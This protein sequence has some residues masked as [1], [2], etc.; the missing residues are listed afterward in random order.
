MLANLAIERR[1]IDPD[2][3]RVSLLRGDPLRDS[4]P[5]VPT[6]WPMRPLTSM[7]RSVY[8]KDPHLASPG[9]AGEGPENRQP[10]EATGDARFRLTGVVLHMRSSPRISRLP[11]GIH[12][13]P[14]TN[15]PA[16]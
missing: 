13:P 3:A 8:F 16:N 5:I 15:L 1:A 4:R 11:I 12:V 2:D 14:P 7:R 6:T 10:R 9:R